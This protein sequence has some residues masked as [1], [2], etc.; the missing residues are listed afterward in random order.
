MTTPDPGN[1]A[2][3]DAR[4]RAAADLRV[5]DIAVTKTVLARIEAA[6]HTE[7]MPRRRPWTQ[8]LAPA[9]FASVLVAT[10]FVV[11][12]YP[13][14]DAGADRLLAALATGDPFALIADAGLGPDL[15]LLGLAE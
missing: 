10:P 7:P 11:A 2:D 4:V 1:D 8:F 5:D 6:R 3:L 14:G 9:T 15:V 13:A 12:N